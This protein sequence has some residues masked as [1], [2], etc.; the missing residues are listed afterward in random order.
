LNKPQQY[1]H[2]GCMQSTHDTHKYRR[3]VLLCRARTIPQMWRYDSAKQN[4]WFHCNA[5]EIAKV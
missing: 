3:H 4:S 2:S 1:V 5:H